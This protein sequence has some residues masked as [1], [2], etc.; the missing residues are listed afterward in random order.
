MMKNTNFGIFEV[1]MN[2]KGEINQLSKINVKECVV[3]K[4]IYEKKINLKDLKNVN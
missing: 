1:G 3:G 4:A 2:R